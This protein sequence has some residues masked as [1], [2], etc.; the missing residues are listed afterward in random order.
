MPSIRLVDFCPIYTPAGL[1]KTLKKKG[2]ILLLEGYQN[3]RK[4]IYGQL[5]MVKPCL[6]KKRKYEK[7][8][9][10]ACNY[11]TVITSEK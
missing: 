7:P 11:E 1:L 8:D 10:F 3:T 6:N 2:G 9:F 4:N 5:L